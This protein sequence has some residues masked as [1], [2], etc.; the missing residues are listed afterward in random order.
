M[1]RRKFLASVLG[2][3]LIL[4]AFGSGQSVLQAISKED[5]CRIPPYIPVLQGDIDREYQELYSYLRQAK[6]HAD[7][8]NKP[9]ILLVAETHSSLNSG[10]MELMIID[11]IQRKE[12]NQGFGIKQF[13]REI[14]KERVEAEQSSTI[15]TL[16]FLHSRPDIENITVSEEKIFAMK[17]ALTDLFAE[18][19]YEGQLT[20]KAVIENIALN[21]IFHQPIAA[22]YQMESFS[23]DPFNK[24]RGK[25]YAA[26]KTTNN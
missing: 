7:A 19:P 6:L 5:K 21:S 1:H 15:R 13:A 22:L 10:L 20:K 12:F 4:D 25:L 2:S 11:I 18:R 9:L 8:Q 3:G 26:K 23:A 16:E 24:E 14:S 17:L